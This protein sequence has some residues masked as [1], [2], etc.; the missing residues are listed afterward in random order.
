[1]FIGIDWGG[2][3][4][5]GVAILGPT[6]IALSNDNDFGIGDNVNGEPS[7]VWIVRLKEPLDLSTNSAAAK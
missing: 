3:K 6:E 7:R 5:E 2:T 4:I 1:M